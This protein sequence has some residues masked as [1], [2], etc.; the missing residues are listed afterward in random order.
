MAIIS[1][2]KNRNAVVAAIGSIQKLSVGSDLQVGRIAS[3]GEVRRQ[4]C[5][6]LPGCQSAGVNTVLEKRNGV[7]QFID[8]VPEEAVFESTSLSL[9]VVSRWPLR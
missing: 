3:A 1:N 9:P 7:L 4:G 8:Q 5:N 6:R 2:S